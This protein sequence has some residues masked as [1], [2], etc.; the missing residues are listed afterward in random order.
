MLSSI[1]IL[2]AANVREGK[3]GDAICLRPTKSNAREGK[4]SPRVVVVSVAA[5]RYYNTF[6][7]G[8]GRPIRRT[9]GESEL[10]RTLK[11][12][13]KPKAGN[14]VQSIGTTPAASTGAA[15]KDNPVAIAERTYRTSFRSGKVETWN[16]K[17]VSEG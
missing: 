15:A 6:A 5:I 4:W 2:K 14:F 17:K 8:Y 3:K 13:G 12:G 1:V 10:R 7:T 9:G 16:M 11:Q